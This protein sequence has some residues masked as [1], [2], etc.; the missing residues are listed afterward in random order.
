MG[1]SWMSS[2]NIYLFVEL[3]LILPINNSENPQ[4]CYRGSHRP[5]P[6]ET[7]KPDQ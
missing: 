3:V 4:Y 5:L 7:N 2:T 6:G 1:F